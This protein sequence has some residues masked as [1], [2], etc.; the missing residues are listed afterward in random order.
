MTV[1][2]T[3]VEKAQADRTDL[4]MLNE[5][6][7]LGVSHSKEFPAFRKS[8]A[9]RASWASGLGLGSLSF[10]ASLFVWLVEQ[11]MMPD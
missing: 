5:S 1:G 8:M 2:V 9:A 10:R 4:L 7:S 6:S 3:L 11:G